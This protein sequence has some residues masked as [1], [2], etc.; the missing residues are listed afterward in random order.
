[1]I[2]YPEHAPDVFDELT[3]AHSN[4]NLR[5]DFS[6]WFET[7]TTVISN[8]TTTTVISNKVRDLSFPDFEGGQEEPSATEPQ[9]KNSEDLPRRR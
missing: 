7:T 4:K 5:E 9:P 6:P 2:V 8:E 3:L 1:L